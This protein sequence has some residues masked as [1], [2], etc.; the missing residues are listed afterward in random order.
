MKRQKMALG[1]TV[2]HPPAAEERKE[3]KEC[4]AGEQATEKCITFIL[5]QQTTY[6]CIQINFKNFNIQ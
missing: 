4:M 1:E 6:S 5:H 2:I 3:I